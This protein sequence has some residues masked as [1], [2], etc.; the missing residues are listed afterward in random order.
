MEIRK[1]SSYSCFPYQGLVF[2]FL[3][4]K[5]HNKAGYTLLSKGRAIPS[6]CLPL[7]TYLLCKAH[8]RR[9]LWEGALAKES[10]KAAPYSFH[11][12]L[13]SWAKRSWA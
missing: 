3:R 11:Y 10:S 13:R 9:A 1:S 5:K 6:Y 7:L 8:P 2:T 12:A 4:D